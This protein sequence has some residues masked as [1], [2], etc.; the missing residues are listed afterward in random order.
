MNRV[1]LPRLAF[2]KSTGFGTTIA[3]ALLEKSIS[4]AEGLGVD[5]FSLLGGELK[6]FIGQFWRKTP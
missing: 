6:V 3:D 5:E 4:D 1:L 2:E